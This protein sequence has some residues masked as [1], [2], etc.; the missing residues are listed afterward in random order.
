MSIFPVPYRIQSVNTKFFA[1]S[2]QSDKSGQEVN[3]KSGKDSIPEDSVRANFPLLVVQTSH[4]FTF[5]QVL[6]TNVPI[7]N[8]PSIVEIV[9]VAP[10]RL[11]VSLKVSLDFTFLYKHLWVYQCPA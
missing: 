11:Y 6:F 1:I 2:S 10:R 5:G 3:T 4:W 9:G 8:G 7:G